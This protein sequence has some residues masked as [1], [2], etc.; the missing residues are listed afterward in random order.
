MSKKTKTAFVCEQCG[1]DFPRWGGQCTS[2]GE[3]NTIKEVRLG[4]AASDRHDRAA[5]YAGSISEVKRLSD[6]N[7]SQAERVL[8]DISEFDRVLGGG[9]VVGSVVLIGGAPG[10]GKST[11][12]LQAIANMADRDVGVLYVSGEESLQ[13][14]AERA[15]RLKLPASKILMLAE[16]S[17]QRICDV[18]DGIKPQILVVDSIQVMHTQDADSAPGSVSQVRESASYLTQYAKKHQVSIFMV[19]H[20][21]KDQSLAG[22]MTLSHIVDTQVMLGSTD[23]ARY[24]VLRADKNRFGSVGELGFFAMDSTGLKEVKNPSAM[25]LNRAETPASGSVVTV[26]WEGTRP[27]LV[28]IQALVVD[29]Q[30]GNPRRLAV[31]FDQ[32][33]LAMLLAVLARHGNIMTAQDEIYANVVGGIK[34][35]ETGSD[36]AIVMSVVSSL[37]NK[38]IPHDALFFGEIGLSG[39]IRP[40]A[41]GHARLNDAAKHGFKKAV[42]PKANAPKHKLADL[43]VYPVS[44]LSEALDVLDDFD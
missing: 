25:F 43:R 33:R 37:K 17:V 20:V 21:T 16:T 15:H 5:G 42:V 24:R 35:S 7:L 30:Y 11:L 32:N 8:T 27:L 13:Q 44:T 1:A 23:D 28:E 38:L 18:M 29:C 22:P 2:C 14:I 39:E 9:M 26:L 34:V 19:G 4:N 12:L 41:N 40:V 10:A 31:G 6:V 36:L 3:W